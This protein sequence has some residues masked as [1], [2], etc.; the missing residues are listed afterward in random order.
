[1]RTSK[2]ISDE[3]LTRTHRLRLTI[4][5]IAKYQTIRIPTAL[6]FSTFSITCDDSKSSILMISEMN[7]KHHDDT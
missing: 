5:G 4:G 2:K 6:F 1:M 7:L 3:M